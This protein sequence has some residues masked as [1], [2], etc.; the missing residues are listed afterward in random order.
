M[1]SQQATSYSS[2]PIVSFYLAH[3]MEQLKKKR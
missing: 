3:T 1:P 2:V